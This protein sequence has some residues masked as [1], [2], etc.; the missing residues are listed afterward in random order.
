MKEQPRFRDI[1]FQHMAGGIVVTGLK[2]SGKPDI[3]TSVP[4]IL[5]R[6]RF[7][8]HSLG[9]LRPLVDA[10]LPRIDRVFDDGMD[11][12]DRGMV[13]I[14]QANEYNGRLIAD[15]LEHLIITD[16]RPETPA[17]GTDVAD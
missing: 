3:L 8:H 14:K 6:L 5:N 4:G 11:M 12:I 13:I 1:N 7:I 16:D 17:P 10:G 15:G 2:D 9:R